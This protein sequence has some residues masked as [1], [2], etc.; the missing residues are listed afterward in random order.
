MQNFL[1]FT[2]VAL[3]ALLGCEPEARGVIEAETSAPDS[4][5]QQ[6]V[7]VASPQVIDFSVVPMSSNST[8]HVQIA[9][10]GLA[11]VEIDRVIFAGHLGFSS[12]FAGQTHQ[13]TAESTSVG[14]RPSAPW[15]VPPGSADSIIVTYTATGP[16]AAQGRLVFLATGQTDNGA[17]VRLHA[18]LQGACITTAP[19]RLSFGAKLVGTASE[20]M[21]EIRSCGDVD[22]RISGVEMIDDGDGA[23][24]VESEAL[25]IFPLTVP[26]GSSLFVAVAYAPRDVG[27]VDAS[28]NFSQDVGRLRIIS[29]AYLAELDVHVDGFGVD[30]SCPTAAITIQ[31]GQEVLPGTLLHLSGAGSSGALRIASYEWSARQP[32]G[33]LA[34]FSPSAYV[35]DVNFEPLTAGEYVFQLEVRD[36]LGTPSCSL[37][38]ATV[39]VIQGNGILVEL[40]WRTPGDLNE[41][42][43]GGDGA[44]FS[45]GSDLDLFLV[46]LNGDAR[47]RDDTDGGGPESI[48]LQDPPDGVYEVRVLYQNDWGYGP[49]FATIRIY[50]NG[51]LSDEWADV[52]LVNRDLWVSHT[53][54]WPSGTVTRVGAEPDI[55]PGFAR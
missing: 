31:E 41:S 29:N 28:G 34:T 55:T 42:D 8:R 2:S 30:G 15:V 43:S 44:T 45:V 11:P 7:L 22:L 48:P 35:S 16:E 51:V 50:I 1:A 18:N 10:S 14:I 54:E 39:L 36:Q 5:T 20:M 47:G 17:E 38:E 52:E 13:I 6:G 24:A 4:T 33:S 25:G 9:N 49:A 23:F 12:T 46:P 21:L 26:P 40:L 37:A 32:N 3:L 27:S 53:I 19:P